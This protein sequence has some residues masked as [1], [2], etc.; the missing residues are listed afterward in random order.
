MGS[1]G[2]RKGGPLSPILPLLALGAGVASLGAGP[3]PLPRAGEVWRWAREPLYGAAHGPRGFV[4]VGR[5]GT[6]L[7][8][9][10]GLAWQPVPSGTGASLEGVAWGAGRFVAVGGQG[11]LLTSE[12]GLRWR[13]VGLGRKAWLADVAWGGR[14]FVAVGEGG[15]ILVSPDGFLWQAVP[16]RTNAFL[17]GVAYG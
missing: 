6:L 5:G 1:R 8:S 2:W 10:D 14:R 15:V 7:Y 3:P 13:P 11:T 9:P 12:D 16:S 4:A 17:Y